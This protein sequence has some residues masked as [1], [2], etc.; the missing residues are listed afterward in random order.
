MASLRRLVSLDDRSDDP[1]LTVVP[2][3]VARLLQA[4]GVETAEAQALATAAH[5][6]ERAQPKH[7]PHRV[8]PPTGMRA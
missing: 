6:A 1:G 4:I 8:T 7:T 3:V 5:D 2:A